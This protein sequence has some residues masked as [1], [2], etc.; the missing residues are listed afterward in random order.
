MTDIP[1]NPNNFRL[2]EEPLSIDYIEEK[3]EKIY[4]KILKCM[5]DYHIVEIMNNFSIDDTNRYT[6]KFG[7]FNIKLIFIFSM[8]NIYKNKK[9]IISEIY[10]R[11]I[12]SKNLIYINNIS[13]S[14]Y[15]NKSLLYYMFDSDDINL[16]LF[17]LKYPDTKI[18]G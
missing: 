17:L 11:Q 3:D 9:I 1:F 4:H 2:T 16:A 6:I 13:K 15:N 14:F 10:D 5:E 7:D 18:L 8:T 12:G